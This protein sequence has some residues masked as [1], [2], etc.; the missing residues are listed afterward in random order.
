VLTTVEATVPMWREAS[1]Y[2][3]LLDDF[4]A[5]SPDHLSEAQLHAKA[6]PLVQPALAGHRKW[7]EKRLLE[8]EGTKV[9]NSLRDIVPAAIMGRVSALFIDCRRARWGHYDSAN[10]TCILHREREPDD[11]DLVELA[12]I[13]TMRHGGDVFDMGPKESGAA[14]TANALLR[15]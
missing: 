13:E 14:E 8:A 1:H 3:F 9:A 7:C 4:I 2:K 6:W 12:A 11:Q 10:N 5:G 15:F